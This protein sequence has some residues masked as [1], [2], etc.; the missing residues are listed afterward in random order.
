MRRKPLLLA[1][2]RLLLLLGITWLSAFGSSVR[3]AEEQVTVYAAASTTNAI[4]EIAALYEKEQ[5][6]KVTASFAA[7]S[8]LARQIE[9]GAPAAVFISADLR[10]MDYLQKKGR[11]VPASRR[12]LLGNTLVLIA[13]KGQGFPVRM[14]KGFDLAAAFKG[15]WCTCD[16]SVPIGQYSQQALTA[17]GWWEVLAPRLVTTQDVRSALAFVE[18]GE[19]ATGIVYETDAKV[20]DKVEILGTFPANTHEPVVYPVA[21]VQGAGRDA[22]EFLDFLFSRQAAAV[23]SKYGFTVLGQ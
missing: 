12:N 1:V 9:Q 4:Q 15:K 8:A 11:I 22:Q 2:A 6:V 23:F 20:S 17:L 16:L 18:R 14:A 13:P 19:C 3:A 21:L 7:S 5:G 10:W